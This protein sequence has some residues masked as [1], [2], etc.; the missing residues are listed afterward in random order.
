[1]KRLIFGSYTKIELRVSFKKILMMFLAMEMP[2]IYQIIW[3]QERKK[4]RI[5]FR[6][7]ERLE[8]EKKESIRSL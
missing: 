4:R 1:M 5:G 6:K 7:Q 2:S 3:K 8:E